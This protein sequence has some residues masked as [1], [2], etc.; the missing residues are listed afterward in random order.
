MS[1]TYT[2][3]ITS[4]KAKNTGGL[5]NAVVQ[6]YWTKT[7]RDEFGNEG[8]FSGATP[9]TVDPDAENFIPF[10]QLTEEQILDWIKPQVVGHYE[11]HVNGQILKQIEEKANDSAEKEVALP[12]MPAAE[13]PGPQPV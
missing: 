7:G 13:T 11:E 12:W 6:T 5:Q 9:I 8:V 1:I 4:I 3:K 10:E 2:W